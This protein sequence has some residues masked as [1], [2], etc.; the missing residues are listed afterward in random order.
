MANA[1]H[2]P[3]PDDLA[4]E[5]HGARRTGTPC[6]TLSSRFTALALDDAY[7]IQMATERRKQAA[8]LR[9]VGH[10]GGPQPRRL[11]RTR[12]SHR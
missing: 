4:S 1:P 6:P 11:W 5:L 9:T 2:A 12:F 8:G 10:K 7:A 3:S